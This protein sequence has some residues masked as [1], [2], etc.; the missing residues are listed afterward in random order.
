[1]I[2][3]RFHPKVVP[4]QFR[5]TL[6]ALPPAVPDLLGDPVVDLV[7]PATLTLFILYILSKKLELLYLRY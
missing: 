6:T 2:P 7:T 3:H 1:M 4:I 5:P